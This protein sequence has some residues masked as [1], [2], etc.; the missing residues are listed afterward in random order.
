MLTITIILVAIQQ[1]SAVAYSVFTRRIFPFWSIKSLIMLHAIGLAVS[2]SVIYMQW[3]WFTSISSVL[4]II[5]Y[6]F[7]YKLFKRMVS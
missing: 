1:L 7:N 2:I 3:Y 5:M 4:T 6:Y